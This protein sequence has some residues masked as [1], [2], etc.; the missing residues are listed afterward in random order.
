[1]RSSNGENADAA[2]MLVASPNALASNRQINV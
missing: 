2:I 1:L